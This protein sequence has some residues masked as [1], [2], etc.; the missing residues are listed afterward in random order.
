MSY[1]TNFQQYPLV[2]GADSGSLPVE[3]SGTV[4]GEWP[5]PS[6]PYTTITGSS[7]LSQATPI[8]PPS[9]S[10][11]SPAGS[12]EHSTASINHAL[13]TENTNMGPI[14][15][16]I[17]PSPALSS[18]LTARETTRTSQ[19]YQR[20][21]SPGF[22]F[23]GL[24][25]NSPSSFAFETNSVSQPVS[26][27]R[28]A[29]AEQVMT[30][31]TSPPSD[32]YRAKR[33]KRHGVNIDN[34]HRAS[35]P[36]ATNQVSVDEMPPQY[37]E[38]GIG[39]MSINTLLPRIGDGNRGAGSPTGSKNR[40]PVVSGHEIFFGFDCGSPDYDLNKNNDLEAIAPIDS[41]E[42]VFIDDNLSPTSEQTPTESLHIRRRSSFTTGGG[43]YVTP[44]RVKIPRRMTPLPSQLLDNPMNLL[45]FHHFIDHT[46]R[47]LVPHD[48][49]E[50]AF[51]KVLPAS[52]WQPIHIF[53]EAGLIAI[54][55]G[56]NRSKSS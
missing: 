35:A 18:S 52:K 38:Q 37:L 20:P 19:T 43:Y 24:G 13:S 4:Q 49:D 34:R 54:N 3:G 8:S 50:N 25:L 46:A 42:E 17:I 32:S 33:Y 45:Y 47:I 40:Q 51:L 15:E 6:S 9:V 10:A 26:F 21:V 31:S 56:H 27:L 2:S 48:C 30:I 12:D 36:N 53:D 29:S 11:K 44:V 14:A 5:I 23:V 39:L 41:S 1:Q 55:S 7:W 16:R 28:D 22:D